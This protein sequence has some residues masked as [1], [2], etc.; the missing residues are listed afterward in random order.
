MVAVASRGTA[1]SMFGA[2]K[3]R[4][5]GALVATFLLMAS[6]LSVLA[7]VDA[8]AAQASVPPVPPSV[9]DA[10]SASSESAAAAAAVKYRHPV[11]VESLTTSTTE[12]SA[13]PDGT[14]QYVS[15]SVPVRV[16]QGQ[17][18]VAVDATL[19]LAK[20]GLIAPRATEVPVEFSAGGSGPLARV[21][22]SSGSWL[23]EASPFGAL[24]APHLKGA[25]ATYPEVLPGVD[26]LLTATAIGMS[27]VLVVKN[28]SAALNPKLH[29]SDSR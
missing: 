9:A 18:W 4:R 7:G 8:A 15:S 25:S 29:R 14:F 22:T 1:M 21:R 13:L 28:K 12:T 16:R 23:E 20:D 11:V 3:V 5:A 6:A 27:E 19:A 17:G 10:Q 24:P 2:G 26:L